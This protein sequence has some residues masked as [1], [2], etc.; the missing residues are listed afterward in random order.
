MLPIQI[1]SGVFCRVFTPRGV[2]PNLL[3]PEHT[4]RRED[5][6]GEEQLDYQ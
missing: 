3:A 2:R 4:R 5:E 6:I 1:G